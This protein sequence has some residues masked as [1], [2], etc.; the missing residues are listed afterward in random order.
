MKSPLVTANNTISKTK[1]SNEISESTNHKLND[2]NINE[3]IAQSKNVCAEI[4][5]EV[6]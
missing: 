5:N 6:C 4:T 2:N 3:S 1:N